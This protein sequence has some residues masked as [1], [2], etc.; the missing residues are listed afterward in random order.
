VSDNYYPNLR[1]LFH[2][3]ASIPPAAFRRDHDIAVHLENTL[4]PN[5]HNR[6]SC[7]F[8]DIEDERDIRGERN[9]QCR[10]WLKKTDYNPFNGKLT[11]NQWIDHYTDA[12]AEARTPEKV[13]ETP[14]IRV[15][16]PLLNKDELSVLKAQLPECI[17]PAIS[18]LIEPHIVAGPLDKYSREGIAG[19]LSKLLQTDKQLRN[20]PINDYRLPLAIWCIE[21]V[22]GQWAKA[23][24]NPDDLKKHIKTVAKRLASLKASG[25]ATPK[26]TLMTASWDQV[27]IERYSNES[28]KV[29]IHPDPPKIHHFAAIGFTDG[30][31]GDLPD[32]RWQVLQQLLRNNGQLAS[33]EVSENVDL[34]MAMVAIR[35]RLKRFV[36]LGDNPI[37][38][39]RRQRA[40]V[41]KFRAQDKAPPIKRLKPETYMSE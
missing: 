8:C 13:E 20:H 27:T 19:W 18:S 28:I 39:D 30:R 4:A 1:A 32:S 16:L 5:E 36:G 14:W 6:R 38:F 12:L 33:H 10:T 26:A 11:F 21:M 17:L 22:D 2:S 3:P 9:R 34:K 23:T 7:P 29:G 15:F 41:A 40:Y 25:A 37:T 24:T 31:K 35:K